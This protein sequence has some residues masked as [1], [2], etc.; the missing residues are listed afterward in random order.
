[1]EHTY[2]LGLRGYHASV[3][4]FRG[5][6]QI[7]IR[8]FVEM[9]EKKIPTKDGLALTEEEFFG[10]VR[11]TDDMKEMIR[12]LD[13]VKATMEAKYPLGDRGFMACVSRFRNNTQVHIRKFIKTEEK[14]IATKDGLVLT[15]EEFDDLVKATNDMEEAVYDF[16]RL[17]EGYDGDDDESDEILSPKRPKLERQDANMKTSSLPEEPSFQ[18]I[19]NIAALYKCRVCERPLYYGDLCHVCETIVKNKKA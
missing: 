17:I 6:I 13:A 8:K 11:A 15:V 4:L 18:D 1:M 14:L 7:H 12:E 2:K 10:I 19:K 9:G 16:E 3:T 5:K